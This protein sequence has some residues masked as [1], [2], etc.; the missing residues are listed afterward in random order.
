MLIQMT[1]SRATRTFKEK[2]PLRPMALAV[3]SIRMPMVV[4]S[5]AR[6]SSS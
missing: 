3:D 6:A 1:L 2:L 4:H 5:G